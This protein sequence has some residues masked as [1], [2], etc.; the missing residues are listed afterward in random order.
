M[1]SRRPPW[2]LQ[3]PVGTPWLEFLGGNGGHSHLFTWTGRWAEAGPPVAA[4]RDP[5]QSCNTD[6]VG[7]L[8]HLTRTDIFSEIG[9]SLLE[10]HRLHEG[11]VGV[12]PDVCVPRDRPEFLLRFR[13]HCPRV[14]QSLNYQIVDACKAHLSKTERAHLG[15]PPGAFA[16]RQPPSLHGLSV[17]S[18]VLGSKQEAT[19]CPRDVQT[20]A[21]ASPPLS[22][23]SN[24]LQSR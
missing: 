24:Q 6:G 9:A 16:D 23:M 17:S 22:G 18:P 2:R 10:N 13:G 1:A 3:T 21:G 7:G 15:R 4:L 11:T 20:P 8:R 5:T 14:P 12:A 19:S